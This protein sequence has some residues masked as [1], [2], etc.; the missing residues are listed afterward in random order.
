[1]ELYPT[2][3]FII[4]NGTLSYYST[5]NNKWNSILLQYL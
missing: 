5:Y 2:I 1:M 3:V 4:I